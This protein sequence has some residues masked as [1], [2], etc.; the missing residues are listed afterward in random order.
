MTGISPSNCNV[1]WA[2]ECGLLLYCSA[3][4]FAR[5][6]VSEFRVVIVFSDFGFVFDMDG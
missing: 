2:A 1:F 5:I 4:R 6:F 3:E